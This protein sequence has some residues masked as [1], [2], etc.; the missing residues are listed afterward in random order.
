MYQQRHHRSANAHRQEGV[1]YESC[2]EGTLMLL[3]SL[4]DNDVPV[5]P[6]QN[7]SLDGKILGANAIPGNGGRGC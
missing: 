1:Y 7:A 2:L 6:D 4:M 5:R 3:C